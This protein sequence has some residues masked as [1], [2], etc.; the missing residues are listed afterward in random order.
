[1]S[2]ITFKQHLF[3]I[4]NVKLPEPEDI[5]SHANRIKTS[6]QSIIDSPYVHTDHVTGKKYK[7]D[8]LSHALISYAG[9]VQSKFHS[10]I[11]PKHTDEQIQEIGKNSEKH[12]KPF[13]DSIHTHY[14]NEVHKKMI[15]NPKLLKSIHAYS[16]HTGIEPHEVVAD[17]FHS[18][19]DQIHDGVSNHI[20][21]LH[22][23]KY[24][25][26][27]QTKE[28]HSLFHRIS[29]DM[30]KSPMGSIY[31]GGMH[32]EFSPREVK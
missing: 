23:K 24:T 16:H 27:S 12:F 15:E 10:Q 1:M 22:Y 19:L 20:D 4:A 6:L 9:S 11:D 18:M 28:G 30:H 5:F 17:A 32:P 13:L 31:N 21:D 14:V 7:F 3:E 8:Q 2:M 26:S 29:E 25:S